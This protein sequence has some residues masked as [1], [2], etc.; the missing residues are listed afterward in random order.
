MVILAQQVLIDQYY[1]QQIEQTNQNLGQGGSNSDIASGTGSGLGR[2]GSGLVDTGSGLGGTGSGYYQHPQ[3]AEKYPPGGDIDPLHIQD[4]IFGASA[5]SDDINCLR[6]NGLHTSSNLK[7]ETQIKM[8]QQ[9]L[10]LRQQ[11]QIMEKMK[12]SII[13]QSGEDKSI[14]LQQ[15][16][17]QQDGTQMIHQGSTLCLSQQQQREIPHAPGT[18][19]LNYS[20]I[21]TSMR[22]G[23]LASA[24]AN[25]T[26]PEM[27]GIPF[28]KENHSE[29]I[30]TVRI[31]KNEVREKNTKIEQMERLLVEYDQKKKEND[32]LLSTQESDILEQQDIIQNQQHLIQAQQNMISKMQSTNS[33]SYDRHNVT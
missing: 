5:D 10:F 1:S 8:E 15:Q 18:P 11:K 19:K 33:L 22:G 23:A 31:L 6:S 29:L 30:K 16:Q 12:F 32:R 2:T 4:R 26:S 24:R 21:N 13:Q 3:Q 25:Q 20:Y 9:R 17:Q 7:T 14:L 28:S 27:S